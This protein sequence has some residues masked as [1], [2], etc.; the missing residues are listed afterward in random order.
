LA[1]IDEFK[2]RRGH[3]LGLKLALIIPEN[4]YQILLLHHF[5]KRNCERP[6][7]MEIV[8]SAKMAA[9]RKRDRSIIAGSRAA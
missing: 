9:V 3:R 1:V 8:I 7:Q 2:E 5:V 6:F 4:I